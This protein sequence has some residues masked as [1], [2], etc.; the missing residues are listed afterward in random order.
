MAGEQERGGAM[1]A[2]GGF[3]T[4]FGRRWRWIA[5]A[6]LAALIGSAV[7]VIAVP[8]RYAGLAKALLDA[9]AGR[10]LPASTA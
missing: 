4:A 3:G 7:F 9:A 5:G 2:R 1:D 10:P 6:T 8:P